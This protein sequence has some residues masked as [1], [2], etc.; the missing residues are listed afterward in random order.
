VEDNMNNETRTID[1]T[2]RILREAAFMIIERG[3]PAPDVAIGAAYAVMDIAETFAG[4]GIPAI[5]WLRT[6]AD[7]MERTVLSGVPRAEG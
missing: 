6:A 5:E 2:R 3:Q 1:Q 7:V 4:Y